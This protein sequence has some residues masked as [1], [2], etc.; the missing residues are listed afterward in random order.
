MNQL[1]LRR[2][3]RHTLSRCCLFLGL[4]GLALSSSAQTLDLLE[5]YRLARQQSPTWLAA[6]AQ[7][8]MDRQELPMARA[9]LLPNL[10]WSMS[11]FK[12]DLTSFNKNFAGQTVS[13]DSEYFSHNKTFTLRQPLFRPQLF[14]AYRQAGAVV[15]SAEARLD[16]S[17]QDLAVRVSGAYF[18][19]LLAHEQ[20]RLLQAQLAASETVLKAS[21]RAFD[22]GQGTKTDIDEAQARLDLH[23]AQLLEAEQALLSARHQ[24]GALINHPVNDL[25]R[26]D[27]QRLKLESLTPNDLAQWITQAEASNPELRALTAS[28]AAAEQ[29][30]MKQRAGHLPTLDMVAQKVDAQSDNPTS[31]NSGYKN[32]QLGIQINFP[33]FAGGYQNAASAR[34]R[35]SLEKF[36]QQYE[37]Q[38]LDISVKVRREFQGVA[39]G[40]LKVRAYEQAEH[41]ASRLVFSTEKGIQAGTRTQIDLLN[42]EQQLML[43]KRDLAQARFLFIMAR[44]RLLAL[45]GSIDE[46]VL[47]EINAYLRPTS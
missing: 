42:A 35:A 3:L 30:L 17:E 5:S 32:S 23:R 21:E 25:A 10:S 43:A 18:E 6:Q 36:R 14:F 40:A 12:N 47:N 28:I 16:L 41:S 2:P 45:T 20:L 37:A 13:T 9:Q 31:S 11:R 46:S 1:Q 22:Q 7:A 38:R 4:A 24:L 29:E 39:E 33:L 34:A 27:P 15:E 26:M 19:A 44:L 8:E